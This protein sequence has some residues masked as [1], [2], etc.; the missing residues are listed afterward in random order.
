[1]SRVEQGHRPVSPRLASNLML[2]QLCVARRRLD[3]RRRTE[4]SLCSMVEDV[5]MGDEVSIRGIKLNEFLWKIFGYRACVNEDYDIMIEAVFV[6]PAAYIDDEELLSGI[7]ESREYQAYTLQQDCWT[8]GGIGVVNLEQWKELSG[9]HTS[10]ISSYTR[11]KLDA[12]LD[13]AVSSVFDASVEDLRNMNIKHQ[14]KWSICS[15]VRDIL[16]WR[17]SCPDRLN[18]NDFLRK[19]LNGRG[20]DLNNRYISMVTFIENPEQFINDDE[21][22]GEIT[23]LPFY[24]EMKCIVEEERTLL[25]DEEKLCNAS[26]VYLGQW[27]D[28][29]KKDMVSPLAREILVA[30]LRN[31]M[32]L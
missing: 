19:E 23:V 13:V 18:L 25:K 16:L 15:S 7:L 11:R 3:A 27:R 32:E 14:P 24:K 10:N 30:A 2:E 28:F 20:V 29:E 4:W 12:A 31:T 21:L 1:M 6:N 17:P 8:L 26:V 22:L 5:L 9:K